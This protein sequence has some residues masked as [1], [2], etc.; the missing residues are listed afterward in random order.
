MY[1]DN[2]YTRILL[3]RTDLSGPQLTTWEYELAR[4]LLFDRMSTVIITEDFARS[5]LQLAC[6]L[7]LDLETARPLLR[8]RVRP[9]ERHQAMLEIPTESDLGPSDVEALRQSFVKKNS[10]DYSLYSHAKR[11]SRARLAQC[12]RRNALVAELKD[13]PVLQ[14]ELP[15]PA[16]KAH[17]LLSVDEMFGCTNG[18]LRELEDGNYMLICPRSMEQSSQSW[19]SPLGTPKRKLG[20]RLPGDSCWKEG[21]HWA[22]CCDPGYGPGGNAACWDQHHNF[23]KCC[24]ESLGLTDTQLRKKSATSHIMHCEHILPKRKSPST[25][26]LKAAPVLSS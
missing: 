5:A 1:A 16:P 8:T 13:A 26:V 6:S 17:P 3:N 25:T 24:A 15:A 7:G 12:A 10:F 18:S 2:Y 9:Y 20:Q 21:F 4:S 14:E 11:I 19:W 22:A 23:A